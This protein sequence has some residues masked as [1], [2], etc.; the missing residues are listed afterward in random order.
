MIL[1]E[2]SFLKKYFYKNISSEFKP[3]IIH[4]NVLYPAAIM[5]DWL[6]KKENKPHIITE[7]WS[8][9]DKFLSKSLY[10]G[11]GNKAYDRAKNITAVSG[12]LKNSLS[13]HVSPKKII[14]VPNV[15]NTSL[16]LFKEKN[17]REDKIFFD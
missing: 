10:A 6:A 3:D 2:F 8:G 13:K 5:G 12:F 4:S 16:F 17:I 14:I 15:I 11:F 7:H 1:V 9:V